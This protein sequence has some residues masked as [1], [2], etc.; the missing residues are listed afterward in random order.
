VTGRPTTPRP[1]RAAA[2]RARAPRGVRDEIARRLAGAPLFGALS[3]E[4]RGEL[5][6]SARI[7]SLPAHQRL[8]TAG[9]RADRLGLVVSG[10][11]K[12]VQHAGGREVILDV[13]LPGEMVGEVAFALG[14]TYQSTVVCLRRARVLVVETDAVR[15]AFDREHR[16]LAALACDLAGQIQRLMRLV[17]SL[18][19]GSV[20]R[21]L[22]RVLLG[23]L[24]RAGERFPGGVYVPVKLRRGD[25]AALAAT[26]EESVSRKIGGWVRQGWLVPQPIGYLVRDVGALRAAAGEG[27]RTPRVRS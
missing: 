27:A 3:P 15:R 11:M 19:A 5:A 6:R 24:E 8:W 2:S 13:V 10:R 20:E 18:S 26:S 1:G 17:E 21:R 16:A 14:A 7:V 9:D 23:L 25:L 4:L 22:A 12:S